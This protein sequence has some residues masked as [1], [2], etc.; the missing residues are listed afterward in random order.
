MS[1]TV[2][3]EGHGDPWFKG[4]GN[5]KTSIDVEFVDGGR[6]RNLISL[7]GLKGDGELRAVAWGGFHQDVAAFLLDLAAVWG[8]CGP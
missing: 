6:I 8:G 5:G 2:L 7:P 4:E 3:N 1:P